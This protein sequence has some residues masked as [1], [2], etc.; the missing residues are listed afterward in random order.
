SIHAGRSAI[1]AI[2]CLSS[3]AFAQTSPSGSGA[4]ATTSYVAFAKSN[5]S[6]PLATGGQPAPLFVSAEDFP[7]VVRAVNDLRAD[8]ERVAGK[9]PTVTTTGAPNGRAV[10]VGTLGKSPVID[11]LVRD[12]KLDANALK[13]KWEAFVIQ[14][15]DNPL[16]G[17][18]QA[19]IV[20]GS[21]KRGTIFGV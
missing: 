20:A 11:R 1:V 5:G 2:A 6:F 17:V 9:A 15:V 12:K 7:G 14:S 8:V 19:L 3:F 18:P 10:I 21:D 16:P 13:G 4:A